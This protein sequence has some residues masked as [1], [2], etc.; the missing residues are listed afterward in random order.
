MLDEFSVTAQRV[1]EMDLRAVNLDA[2]RS[3]RSQHFVH[4]SGHIGIR[5]S[6]TGNPVCGSIHVCFLLWLEKLA[7]SLS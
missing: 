4:H 3:H 2:R 1:R 7:R 5:G 6:V